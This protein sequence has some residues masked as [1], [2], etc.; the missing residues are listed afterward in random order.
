MN[1]ILGLILVIV[2][3]VPSYAAQR[4]NEE[5]LA[6]TRRVQSAPKSK[7]ELEGVTLWCIDSLMVP[8]LRDAVKLQIRALAAFNAGQV[9]DGNRLI[10]VSES[11]KEA[12]RTLAK[13]LCA[14]R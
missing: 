14:P 1:K 4:T 6:E 5:I 3:A 9:E 11:S 12:G 13:S 8:I 7:A 10:Q 2:F